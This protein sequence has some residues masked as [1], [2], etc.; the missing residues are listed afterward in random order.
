MGVPERV[1]LVRH[2]ESADPAVFHGAES[3]VGLSALGHRQADAAAEWFRPLR[4]TA[5]VSSGM[6][7]AVDTAAPIAAACGLPLL[8]EPGLHE[9]RVGALGGTTFDPDRGPWADTVRR[10]TAGD[11]AYT[12]PG[13]ESFD[14]LRDRVRAAWDRVVA[15]HPGDRVVV[16]AHG[17]VCKVLLLTL[18]DEW[19]V[20]DWQ[21]I[22]RVANLA[23]SELAS[24]VSGWQAHQLLVVPDP[25]AALTAGQP[26]GVGKLGVR[27]EA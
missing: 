26:T 17:V 21:R 8:A 7:R 14:D 6:R 4:P 12:T 23:V 11:T 3:D 24:S 1:W 5:V 22:G 27:S 18:L 20:G 16:V 13:A 25:V 2:A 19:G 9:R 10:W 15:A